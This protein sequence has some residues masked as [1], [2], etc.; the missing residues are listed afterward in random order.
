MKVL[1]ATDGSEF[2]QRAVEKCCRMF[3]ESDDTKLR[4]ISAAAPVIPAT[5][6]LGISAGF[7]NDL[8]KAAEVQAAESISKAE[9]EVRLHPDLAT[10]LSSQVINGEPK[11]VIVD[12]AEQWGADVIVLGTHGYGFWQRALLGSVSDSVIRHAPCSV[13]VVRKK[14]L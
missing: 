4:I 5:D 11:R 8:Q 6:P 2:S 3:D 12:E 14:R 10:D 7:Y 13:L 9:H 1:I